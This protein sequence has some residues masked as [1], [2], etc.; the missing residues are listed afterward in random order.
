MWYFIISKHVCSLRIVSVFYDI[1]HQRYR[2][3]PVVRGQYGTAAAYSDNSHNNIRKRRVYSYGHR[4][5]SRHAIYSDHTI[6]TSSVHQ[7]S[8]IRGLAT[9]WTYFLHFSLSFVILIDHSTVSLI[10]MLMSFIQATHGL[11]HLHLPCI[12]PCIISSSRQ[13][14]CFLTT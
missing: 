9:S 4:K 5:N 8:L 13:F 10:H 12:V 14:P 3:T 11:H 7:P 2:A 6:L 1:R